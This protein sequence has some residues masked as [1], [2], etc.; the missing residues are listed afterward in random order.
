MALKPIPYKNLEG[1]LRECLSR[2][3]EEEETQT[4]IR[5]L[6]GARRR[7]YLTPGELEAVC[8]WKSARAVRHI[9][10]NTPWSVRS[11]TRRAIATRS[12]RRRL[13]LLCTL[14]GVSVPMA[15]A[16]LTLLDPRRYGVIDIRVWQ[17]LYRLGAVTRKPNGTGF[18]FEDWYRFL[19]IVRYF[20]RKL[21]VKTRDIERTL[22]AVHRKYQRGRLYAIANRRPPRKLSRPSSSGGRF[23]RR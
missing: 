17:I 22:F 9:K 5:K 14:D 3:E 6:R 12:E 2:S 10:A 23:A 16:I 19:M 20:A 1:L 13:E 15:S 21:G 11:L 8:R 7:G 18:T 4:V